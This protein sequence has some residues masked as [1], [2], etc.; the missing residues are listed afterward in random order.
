MVSPI[1][2]GALTSS[3]LSCMYSVMS[4]YTRKGRVRLI[5]TTPSHTVCVAG[6]Y[7]PG[8]PEKKLAAISVVVTRL[9]TDET[10]ERFRADGDADMD[11]V[12]DR[13]VALA[14]K[15]N[16]PLSMVN[17]PVPLEKCSCSRCD[18][19]LERSITSKDLA[20]IN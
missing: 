15:Y 16:A 18:G 13:A 20:R 10:V 1:E 11:E 7:D 19:W 17:Q 12:T 2:D 5:N 6:Y 14:T 3:T 9:D 8:D 4:K